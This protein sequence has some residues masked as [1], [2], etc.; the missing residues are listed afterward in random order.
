VSPLREGVHERR[1]QTHAEAKAFLARVRAT[2]GKGL[3]H[4]TTSGSLVRYWYGT[5]RRIPR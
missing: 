1:F 5:L 2:G 3:V 4:R